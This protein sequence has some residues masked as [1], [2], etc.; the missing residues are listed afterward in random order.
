MMSCT[1]SATWSRPVSSPC[2]T[3]HGQRCGVV[4][5]DCITTIAMSRSGQLDLHYTIEPNCSGMS[6]CL[7]GVSVAHDRA[8]DTCEPSCMPG[9]ARPFFFPVVH[10]P[11]GA[12]GTWQH[13]SSPLGEVRSGSRGS[14]GTHL[15]RE[16][17]SGAEEHVAAPELSFRGGR[18]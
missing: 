2:Y 8:L 6:A 10:S 5:S 3:E 15:G 13:R 12:M 7:A 17:T 18:V 11:L 16:A 4:M 9:A 14:T 1:A